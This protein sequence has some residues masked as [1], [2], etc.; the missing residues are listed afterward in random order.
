M[1]VKNGIVIIFLL[2]LIFSIT[3]S[4]IKAEILKENDLIGKWAGKIRVNNQ[5]LK[6]VIN[7]FSTSQGIRGTIDIPSQ[8]I[9][10]YQLQNIS[11]KKNEINFE[12]PAEETGKFIGD[13]SAYEI[14]GEY[15]QDDLNGKFHLIKEE[16]KDKKEK[17]KEKGNKNKDNLDTKE[18][19]MEP[20]IKPPYPVLVIFSDF[21]KANDEKIKTY[22]MIRELFI[23]RGYAVFYY[24]NKKFNFSKPMEKEDF[25][26]SDLVNNAINYL[27]KISINP[28][29]NQINIFGEGQG[30]LLSLAA[31]QKSKLE[32]E[33][34]TFIEPPTSS[35]S[36]IILDQLYGLQNELFAET[37]YII[38]NL[39][40]G[41]K[42]KKIPKELKTFFS[43]EI[44]PFL[45]SWFDYK[46]LE[47]INQ[48]KN[49]I[50]II[51]KDYKKIPEK[52][53][54]KDNIKYFLVEDNLFIKEEKTKS[55]YLN[56]KFIKNIE[57]FM[58]L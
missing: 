41:K 33:S 28:N 14:V 27:E 16:K 7:F 5:Q 1:K 30:V 40:K 19:E 24:E 57:E 21:G 13:F 22:Q 54:K 49:K 46:P 8:N 15:I 53:I 6:I 31:V 25:N 2:L 17:I 55:I 43:P 20:D 36:K 58:N 39:E 44:Q 52:I 9:I 11:Y 29:Y 35:A 42:V 18:I 32:I 10:D 38:N 47:L 50:F 34:F 23:K 26:Y 3:T 48:S 4:S 51:E 12:I 37:R 56:E 45:I